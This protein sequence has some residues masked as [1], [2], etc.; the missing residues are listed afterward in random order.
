MNPDTWA[1]IGKPD[2][3][4]ITKLSGEYL[5]RMI[6][7]AWDRVDRNGSAVMQAN[8]VEVVN[9][10]KAFIEEVRAKTNGLESKW[11]TEAKARGLADPAAVLKEYR[12]LIAAN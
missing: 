2:Q 4:A 9:A 3:E 7:R 11:L 8:G 1:R 6:G 5:A 10:D 12:G